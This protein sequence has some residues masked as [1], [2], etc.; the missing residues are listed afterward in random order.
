MV[1]ISHG[2]VRHIRSIP[3]LHFQSQMG[4]CL[5]NSNCFAMYDATTALTQPQHQ[6]KDMLVLRSSLAHGRT[7]AQAQEHNDSSV[8][9]V[10][11]PNICL[12]LEHQLCQ[13]ADAPSVLRVPRMPLTANIIFKVVRFDRSDT[14]GA[15]VRTDMLDLR[16][17]I[18]HGRTYAQEQQHDNS[19]VSQVLVFSTQA[20]DQQRLCQTGTKPS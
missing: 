9:V 4:D 19:S 17:R 14:A 1:C 8:P 13:T 12:R 2:C 11:G 10:I 15:S 7:H 16:P 3:K 6:C 20:E 18:A 5:C